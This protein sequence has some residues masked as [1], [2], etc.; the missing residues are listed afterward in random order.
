MGRLKPEQKISYVG[1]KFWENGKKNI[2]CVL[3]P[4][5]LKKFCQQVRTKRQSEFFTIFSNLTKKVSKIKD[6]LIMIV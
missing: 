4:L 3:L 5:Y 2:Y 1:V 6:E